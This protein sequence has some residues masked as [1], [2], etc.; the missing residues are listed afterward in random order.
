MTI[1]RRRLLI[2]PFLYDLTQILTKQRRN[3][4][5]KFWSASEEPVVMWLSGLHVP[6]S[7]IT[8][9]VQVNQIIFPQFQ[10]EI[11]LKIDFRQHVGRTYG[12]LIGPRC[13]PP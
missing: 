13:T 12:H 2:V 1:R 8:A 9:L 4:Q 10:L 6:E 11:N 3:K 5:Y 7:Y